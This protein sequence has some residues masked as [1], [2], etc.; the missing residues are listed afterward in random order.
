[1]CADFK[2]TAL[3][4]VLAAALWVLVFLTRPFD[5][6]LMLGG[7]TF[8]LLVVSVLISSKRLALHTTVSFVLYGVLSAVMLY[9]LFRVGYD[10]TKSIPIFSQG[11]GQVYG[12]KSS[13]PAWVIVLLLIFPIGPGEEIYWRGLVQRAF[14]EKTSPNISLLA[15]SIC[16]ALVHLPT[17]NPPLIMTALIGG[18]V[19]GSLYKWTHSLVPGIVSHVL[20]DLMIFVLIPLV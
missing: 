8:I 5:F 20:W 13:Q 12:L 14:A 1:L 15:A 16:Y 3:S 10:F 4:L 17:F 19:W 11:V 9:A 7:S 18:L 6:W 2:P